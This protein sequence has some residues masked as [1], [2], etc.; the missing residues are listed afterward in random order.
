[1]KTLDKSDKM[2]LK[3]C[4]LMIKLLEIAK[5]QGSFPGALMDYWELTDAY[6]K[7]EITTEEYD[8]F[9][10]SMLNHYK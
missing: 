5:I 3:N 10:E 1:M 9:V 8:E 2:F 6:R 4:D 7:D